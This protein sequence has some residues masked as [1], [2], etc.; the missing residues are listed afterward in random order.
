MSFRRD[1][2]LDEM[3]GIIIHLIRDKDISA[4]ARLKLTELYNELLDYHEMTQ[5]EIEDLKM[6][7]FRNPDFPGDMMGRPADDFFDDY[8]EYDDYADDDEDD[9]DDEA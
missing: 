7:I 4:E 3:L 5:D 2:A 1:E 8:E 6:K 9:T